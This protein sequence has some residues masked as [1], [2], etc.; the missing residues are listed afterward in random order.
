MGKWQ[1]KAGCYE[2]EV[3]KLITPESS[4]QAGEWLVKFESPFVYDDE[5]F[6]RP[7]PVVYTKPDLTRYTGR[8]IGVSSVSCG[9]K[10]HGELVRADTLTKSGK[11]IKLTWTRLNGVKLTKKA[12]TDCG[13][14]QLSRAEIFV[15]KDKDCDTGIQLC[16]NCSKHF[17]LELGDINDSEET[18][19][20]LEEKPEINML[21]TWKAWEWWT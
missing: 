14:I 21:V 16:R 7:I 1:S 10:K 11:K 2:G 15:C 3:M 12:C 13:E 19:V 4:R 6:R 17:T 8:I 9:V 18:S 20:A 5:T